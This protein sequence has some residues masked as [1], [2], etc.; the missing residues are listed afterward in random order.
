[1]IF[2][3]SDYR[4]TTNSIVI[5]FVS[6]KWLNLKLIAFQLCLPFQTSVNTFSILIPHPIE[7]NESV[8]QLSPSISDTKI[9]KIWRFV[10][11]S[12]QSRLAH[13]EL[14]SFD[15]NNLCKLFWLED[16]RSMGTNECDELLKLIFFNRTFT[17][18]TSYLQHQLGIIHRDFQ[19]LPKNN[20]VMLHNRQSE[21]Q[22]FLS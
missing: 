14:L 15:Q 21:K 2:L 18:C 1:M 4:I 5:A 12:D 22:H 17:F 8:E 10:R 20:L 13:S 3:L 7:I 9:L 16:D 6:I 19:R 11:I